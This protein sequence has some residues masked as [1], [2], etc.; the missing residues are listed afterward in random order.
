MARL[1]H[2]GWHLLDAAGVGP[3]RSEV[4]DVADVRGQVAADHPDRA[5]QGQADVFAEA[6][7][8]LPPRPADAA[9]RQARRSQQRIRD[10]D[11]DA[12]RGN[13]V[14]RPAA[15]RRLGDPHIG[16]R[17]RQ[18][19]DQ[20]QACLSRQLRRGFRQYPAVHVTGTMQRKSYE[21]AVSCV[22]VTVPYRRYSTNSAQW[23]LGRAL[24]ELTKRAKLQ[25]KDIDGFAV[26]SF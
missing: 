18:A 20:A 12:L 13:Q 16:R 26:S 4:N 5:A 11:S 8:P 25:P 1:V 15:L 21:G 23:W 17:R 22:P 9:D 24:H 3:D 2:R 7:E 14:R 19:A 10:L 6:Q